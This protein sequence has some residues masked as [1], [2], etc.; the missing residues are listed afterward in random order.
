M[1]P[2]EDPGKWNTY[3]TEVHNALESVRNRERWWERERKKRD[4]ERKERVWERED[5]K[6]IE[7]G[8]GLRAS[9]PHITTNWNDVKIWEIN[10]CCFLISTK[11]TFS[12][13][14]EKKNNTDQMKPQPRLN[15]IC[16]K[17]ILFENEIWTRRRKRRRRRTIMN[18][19]F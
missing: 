15:G 2:V 16:I 10:C 19:Q 17:P 18:T 14:V 12:L 5:W 1:H 9:R 8:T 6:Y 4:R 3:N 13:S 7:N 11:W